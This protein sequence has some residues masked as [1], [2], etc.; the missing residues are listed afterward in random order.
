MS[1]R[2]DRPPLALFVATP[3]GGRIT[4]AR[5]DGGYVATSDAGIAV[6]PDLEWVL[7]HAADVRES[8]A[9]TEETARRVRVALHHAPAHTP[10]LGE[11]V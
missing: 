8:D 5:R 10:S 9:W 4:V 11:T 1:A 2:N 6:G 7:A 3:D